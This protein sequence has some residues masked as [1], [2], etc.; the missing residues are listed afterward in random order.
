M[1]KRS[2]HTPVHVF[3]DNTP[4]FITGAIYLKRPLLSDSEI[5]QRLLKLIQGYF[6][7][8]GWEL[9][10][11]VILD[12]HYHII[13]KSRKGKDLSAIMKNIHWASGS[14]VHKAT[15][16]AK[17]I[18]W[19]YWDY[20]PRDEKDYM[21]RLNY[22]L[23]NPV[24]HGYTNNL[25]DYLFSSFHKIYSEFGRE[26]LARQF[27]EYSDYRTLVLTEKDDDF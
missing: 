4:Y 15:G 13:G 12:N 23:N 3:A 16:G 8:Y 5:K 6:D 1:L 7:E 17:P 2:K 19:N 27:R 22:L 18:W 25:K 24:K 20:C 11:W 26:K 10:H 21:T 14:S 9:H